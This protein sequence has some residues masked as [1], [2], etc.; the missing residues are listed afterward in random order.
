MK[1]L[2]TSLGLSTLPLVDSL[3]SLLG[4]RLHRSVLMYVPT[5]LHATPG[6]A[7]AGYELLR[8]ARPQDWASVGF[9]ELTALHDVPP[10][11]WLSDLEAADAIMIGGGNTPYLSHWLRRSRF[12]E[13][14]PR[15]LQR[16]VYVGV[17][18]GSIVAGTNMHIDADRLRRDGIYDDDI[19]GDQAPVGAGSSNTLGLVPFAIRPHLGS[20]DL[21]RATLQ[22]LAD[23]ATGPTYAINDESAIAVTN[24]V[25]TP[26][27]NGWH[28]LP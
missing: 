9:L 21:P 2:L 28:W 1:L 27:G 16:S 3:E 12:D 5:A 22:Y 11:H 10:E 7:A 19:Y 13:L 25:V 15:L 6:G 26:V 23:T 24:G 17:S 14:L 8:A 20:P 4:K 18:A